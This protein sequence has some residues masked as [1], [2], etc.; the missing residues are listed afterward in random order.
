MLQHS[1]SDK[2]W[3]KGLSY[4][5]GNMTLQAA[6]SDDLAR[7]LNAAVE[8]D[9]IVLPV[10][11]TMKH[12]LDSWAT[13][14]GYPVINVNRTDENKLHLSQNK[15]TY[16][17]AEENPKEEPLWIIPINLA[18][19]NPDNTQFNDT[20]P[21]E[22]MTAE[23]LTLESRAG[24]SWND[25][26]W[27]IIN[28]QQTGY[29][30]VNY[31]E[32]LWKLLITKLTSESFTDI[33]HINRAQLVDDVLNLGRANLQP[34][35]TVFDLLK[36]LK[37][38]RD[39]TPWTSASTGLGYLNRMLS[40]SKHFGKFHEYVL[41]LVRPIYAQ[42]G[43]HDL[44][45]IETLADKHLRNIA[46]DWACL[47]GEQKCL[48]ET[49]TRVRQVIHDSSLD[50][51]PDVRYNVYCSGLRKANAEDFDAI[52]ERFNATTNQA[53]RTTLI[54]SMGCVENKDIQKKYLESTIN[55]KKNDY[56]VQERNRVLQGVY[57]NGKVGLES[58]MDFIKTNHKEIEADYNPPSPVKNSIMSMAQRVTSENHLTQFTKLIDEMITAGYI[59][60]DEKT[61]ILETPNENLKWIAANDE[62]IGKYLNSGVIPSVSI[63]SLVL[64]F[65]ISLLFN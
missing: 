38:E 36:Y 63:F 51:E 7:N 57:S 3:V 42:Y 34:Y 19:G 33:H 48:D 13:K 6:D 30:R 4:Y 2:T 58:A 65:I 15:F 62:E 41:E 20:T 64:L 5:L 39:F 27:I 40:D 37:Q 17:V 18:T 32:G 12:I 26:H 25:S 53:D 23:N 50:I 59:T 60:N 24:L 35:S 55:D 45:N 44:G 31:D 8:E 28:K 16:K 1:I 29:Y 61:K 11:T 56:R 54:N 10:N 49:G 47:T 21:L 46:I 22:W 43:T 9:K 14:A 52:W